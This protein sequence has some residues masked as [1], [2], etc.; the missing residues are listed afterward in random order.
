M[1]HCKQCRDGSVV[2]GNPPSCGGD[3]EEVSLSGSS[4]L[5]LERVAITVVNGALHV[6]SKPDSLGVTPT[7]I[8]IDYASHEDAHAGNV[9]IRF[10]P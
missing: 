6:E 3:E 1:P 10:I 8:I 2:C 9:R 7:T 4:G 5:D